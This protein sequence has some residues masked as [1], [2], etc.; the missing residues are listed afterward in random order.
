MLK[1][2]S[3][4]PKDARLSGDKTKFETT[5][6][7]HGDARVAMTMILPRKQINTRHPRCARFFLAPPA[8]LPR[9]FAHG[10]S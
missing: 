10:I 7:R 2:S 8:F 9:A 5:P 4:H 1:K 3:I 6:I